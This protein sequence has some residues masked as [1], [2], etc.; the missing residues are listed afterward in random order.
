M[1]IIITTKP[2][3]SLDAEY[4]MHDIQPRKSWKDIR[5][6]VFNDGKFIRI[7]DKRIHQ[8][9]DSRANSLQILGL[10]LQL[11]GHDINEMFT[12]SK[13]VANINKVKH[14]KVKAKSLHNGAEMVC[15]GDDHIIHYRHEV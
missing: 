6:E 14:H 2:S 5:D 7:G 11:E 13:C 12:I 1:S 10:R 9:V 4:S 8:L 3:D 15:V